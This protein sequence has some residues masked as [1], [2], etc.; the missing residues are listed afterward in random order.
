MNYGLYDYYEF[1]RF[2][3]IK[4]NMLFLMEGGFLQFFFYLAPEKNQQ[5]VN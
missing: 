2:L 5:K 3:F 4:I 1:I